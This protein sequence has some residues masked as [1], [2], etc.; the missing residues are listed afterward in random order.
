MIMGI[1][2]RRAG[3]SIRICLKLVILA[4]I[5][6]YLLPRMV[7]LYWQLQQPGPKFREEQYWEK[8]L[9]VISIYTYTT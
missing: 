3:Q 4:A 6:F 1:S 9:R 5:L 7:A 8:P 2:R